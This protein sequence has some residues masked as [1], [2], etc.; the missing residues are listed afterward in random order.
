LNCFQSSS[1]TP[2]KGDLLASRS[3]V[4]SADTVGTDN[5][6]LLLLLLLLLL[7]RPLTSPLFGALG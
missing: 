4:L 1:D 5:S 3:V 7:L 2:G 6:R